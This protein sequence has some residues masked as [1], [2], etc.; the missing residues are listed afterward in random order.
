MTRNL[1]LGC[2]ENLVTD[3][4]KRKFGGGER[5]HPYKDPDEVYERLCPQM[6]RTLDYLSKL[7]AKYCPDD[8][9]VFRIDLH[10]AYLAKSYFPTRL[11]T[12]FDLRPVG[13]KFIPI[14]PKKTIGRKKV[15]SQEVQTIELYI[16]GLRRDIAM[17]CSHLQDE[18][19]FSDVR[20]VERIRAFDAG[21][22]LIGD[23]D[24]LAKSKVFELVLHS[25]RYDDSI[26]RSFLELAKKCDMEVMPKKRIQTAGLCF[27][28]VKAESYEALTSVEPFS[29]LRLVRRMPRLREISREME[30]K[31]EPLSL[32]TLPPCPANI[33]RVAVFDVGCDVAPQLNGWVSENPLSRSL[34]SR[35]VKHGTMVNSALLFGPVEKTKPLNPVAHI[36]SYQVIDPMDRSSPLELY[37]ALERICQK[38]DT[39]D[40]EFANLSIGPNLP[41]EDDEVHAWTATLD[42]KLASGRTLM[43]VAVGNNGESDF[44]SGNA[45]VEVPGDSVNALS[46][47]ASTVSGED[48]NW[49]RSSYSAVGPGR[50]PGRI[51]PD[52]LDF[53]GSEK[54]G[55]GVIDPVGSQL[56]HLSGTSFA[57]PNALHKCIALK[58]KYPELTPLAL[59][60]LMIHTASR[61]RD[62]DAL[63]CGHGNLPSNLDRYVVC[64]QD[65]MTVVYQ[66]R[67]D[68]RK[69]VKAEI[70]VPKTLKGRITLRATLCYA[71]GVS[72]ETPGNYTRSAIE[73]YL[74]PNI[75]KTT[76]DAARPP[77]KPFFEHGPYES[78]AHLREYGLK[79]DTVM[80]GEKSF[81]S[82]KSVSAPFFELHYMAREGMNYKVDAGQIPYALIVTIKAP[83]TPDIYAQVLERYKLKIRPIVEVGL[84]LPL[85]LS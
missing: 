31:V 12:K 47:G 63:E 6:I 64:G 61:K 13:S 1:L 59:K 50:M 4:P 24:D 45:R 43:T 42:E 78:E 18:D 49:E 67:L 77:S 35:G 44:A 23:V 10:P 9:S 33:P 40:Y 73:V 58:T 41:I 20:K 70:P 15:G 5:E 55:F 79:W 34:P 39:Y 27:L 53:G 54:N 11:L 56:M 71:T 46:V 48:P 81:D 30:G 83:K 25:D 80:Q 14:V 22:R 16:A 84:P 60:A 36:D 3:L 76:K 28:P 69:Y 32:T 57:A 26:V 21:E 17:L 51:K 82:S 37:E 38:L 75:A 85:P 66:G 8:H 65:E 7:D 2:G 68:P 74:R 72:P 62:S 29:F 52:V 19:L